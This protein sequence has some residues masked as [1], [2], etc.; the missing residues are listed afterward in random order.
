VPAEQLPV[1]RDTLIYRLDRLE[2]ISRLSGADVRQPKR[3]LAMYLACVSDP[4]EAS[5]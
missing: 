5:Q 3:A 4:V 2:K 1:H